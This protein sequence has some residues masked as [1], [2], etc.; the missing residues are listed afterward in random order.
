MSSFVVP[1]RFTTQYPTKNTLQLISTFSPLATAQ[2]T[3]CSNTRLVLLKMGIMMSETCSE[4]VDNKHLTVASCWFSLSLQNLLTMHGH[5]N[6]KAKRRLT[7]THD[8][9]SFPPTHADIFV[10]ICTCLRSQSLLH[11]ELISHP[12]PSNE[13]PHVDKMYIGHTVKV[14]ETLF[15][16]P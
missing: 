2:H 13:I 10:S 4:S 11:F 14:Y 8:S 3:T 15:P 6:L 7:P 9:F 16:F 12:L 1:S 5:R